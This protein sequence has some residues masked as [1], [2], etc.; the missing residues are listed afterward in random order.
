MK[1]IKAV[2]KS[3]KPRELQSNIRK[4]EPCSPKVQIWAPDR[5]PLAGV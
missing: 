1:R 5:Y 2:T 4:T 3:H